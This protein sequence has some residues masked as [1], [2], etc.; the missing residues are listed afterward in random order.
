MKF[1][2][3]QNVETLDTCITVSCRVTNNILES[4][5]LDIFI[6]TP[7]IPLVTNGSKNIWKVTQMLVDLALIISKFY[8]HFLELNNIL[9]MQV[10]TNR[11]TSFWF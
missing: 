5:T 8:I 9:L 6:I 7:M 1:L 11:W 3:F 10:M 2:D 4:L